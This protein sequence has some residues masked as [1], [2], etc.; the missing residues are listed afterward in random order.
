MSYTDVLVL[1]Q[2]LTDIQ[3]GTKLEPF[4]MFLATEVNGIDTSGRSSVVFNKES[5]SV[6]YSSTMD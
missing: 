3:N 1:N 2:Y 4:M 6:H 5:A